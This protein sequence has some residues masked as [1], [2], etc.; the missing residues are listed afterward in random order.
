MGI[1]TTEKV[2]STNDDGPTTPVTSTREMRVRLVLIVLTG[3][4][5]LAT[6]W[7]FFNYLQDDAF[8]TLRYA[9]NYA[10]GYGWVLTAGDPVEGY[11]SPAH[12]WLVTAVLKHLGT[13]RDVASGHVIDSTIFALKYLGVVIGVAVLFLTA[14]LAKLALPAYPRAAWIAP[15]I[16]A[17]H[18]GF[19]LSMINVMETGMA[20][21]FLTYGLV[22]FLEEDQQP[23][24]WQIP[25]LLVFITAALTRPEL[26]V[27]YPALLL[28]SRRN[29]RGMLTG[30]AYAAAIACFE[31]WRHHAY[32]AWLPN[33]YYAKWNPLSQI[34]DGLFYLSV[35]ALPAQVPPG[36]LVIAWGFIFALRQN[37]SVLPLVVATAIYMAFVVTSGGDWMQEGRFVTPILPAVSVAI[38]AGLASIVS[39]QNRKQ[40]WRETSARLAT[41]PSFGTRHRAAI[42]LCVLMLV[43]AGPRWIEAGSIVSPR[44]FA[45]TIKPHAPLLRWSSCE[46]LGRINMARWVA[47]HAKPGQLVVTSELGLVSVYN[48]RV[49]FVDFRGLADSHI[50]RMAEYQHGK[51]G[52]FIDDWMDPNRL[53]A[54]YLLSR[55]P[56]YVI[57]LD[58][59][60]QY[61]A[62]YPASKLYK[63]SGSFYIQLDHI[64]EN[65][66]LVTTWARKH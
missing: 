15:L 52:V 10:M 30:I 47:S 56:D 11:T 44:N 14:R 34:F 7:R 13:G 8:I 6:V 45:E 62:A 39:R 17:W 28:V 23:S 38:A 22:R 61:T 16:V 3:A 36:F 41:T 59:N 26:T 24:R 19:G 64:G 55:R 12:L 29:R 21:L 37:R 35:N 43:D 32:G 27:I 31:L 54:P 33:T 65:L 40:T 57:I 63:P 51:Y 42:A 4:F 49:N 53:A 60:D 25:S 66:F 50:S 20:T 58:D 18:P 48:P 46:P 1:S 9:L 5:Y 2:A